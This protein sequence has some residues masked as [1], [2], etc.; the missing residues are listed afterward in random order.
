VIFT[1]IGYRNDRMSAR[2]PW[3]WPSQIE[4]G[5]NQTDDDLQARC[6]QA[7]F[8]T[9]WNE[10]WMAGAFF[11][12]WFHSTWRFETRADHQ[13]YRQQRIDS[14]IAAGHARYARRAARTIWFSP[15]GRPAEEVLRKYYRAAGSVD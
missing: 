2:E 7:F 13:A 15:Q 3:L 10:P 4:E 5:E 12:K 11:W 8:E 1:E 14:L 6:Y 9:C